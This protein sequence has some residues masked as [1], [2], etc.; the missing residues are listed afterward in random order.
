MVVVPLSCGPGAA[1]QRSR[2]WCGGVLAMGAGWLEAAACGSRAALA[3]GGSGA[4]AWAR[5]A[6]E[7]GRGA[8]CKLGAAHDQ[9]PGGVTASIAVPEPLTAA[10]ISEPG[11]WLSQAL[12]EAQG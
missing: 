5:C 4:M 10:V 2:C 12:V 9:L 8:L 1:W 3:S 11:P 6:S 7:P